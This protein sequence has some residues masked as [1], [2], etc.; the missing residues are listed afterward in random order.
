MNAE[1]Q[2]LFSKIKEQNTIKNLY[3]LSVAVGKLVPTNGASTND[4]STNG[5]STNGAPTN[6]AST[7]GNGLEI[8]LAYKDSIEK[9][10]TPEKIAKL[11]KILV[12]PIKLSDNNGLIVGY[13]I[14]NNDP[15]HKNA[16]VSLMMP[17][18]Y[19]VAFNNDTTIGH[20]VTQLF[21]IPHIQSFELDL[22]RFLQIGY[23]L[24]Q[25]IGY[26]QYPEM[27]DIQVPNIIAEMIVSMFENPENF[28]S[29][30]QQF[31]L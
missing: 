1:I 8:W 6:G 21:R 4:A 5:A 16:T 26:R 24:G 29:E 12:N 11:G 15:G 14:P 28:L 20:F 17:L 31:N 7:N 27:C 9:T 22:I 25:F 18:I 13:E 30:N 23:N 19:G 10:L 3:N 2:S